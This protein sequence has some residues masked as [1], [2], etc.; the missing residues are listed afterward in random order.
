MRFQKRWAQSPR[1]PETSVMGHVLIVAIL[2][3]FCA[4]KMEANDERI[5]NDFLCGLFHDLP[6]VLTR[7]IISPIKRS[8]TGL[9]DLIKDIEKRQVADKI[10]P[11]LPNKWH[12]EI[13]YF[14][15]D[16]FSNRIILNGERQLCTP[17][18]IAYKYNEDGKGYRAI[19]GKDLKACDNLAAFVEAN[20]SI[21][22]GI[23]SKHLRNA[24][25]SLHKQYE[26]NQISGIDFG[27]IYAVFK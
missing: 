3:Y 18:E 2:A 16:E 24:V 25:D 23:S 11:L 19:D 9:D 26:N 15:E 27:K 14:T 4:I 21:E 6:E 13:L 10:L 8:I 20:L 17:E 7:D 5:I 1:V 12:E 22:Y